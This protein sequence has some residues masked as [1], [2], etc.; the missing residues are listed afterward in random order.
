MIDKHKGTPF[1][2]QRILR[3]FA[4]D[5]ITRVVFS[6]DTNSTRDPTNE[7]CQRAD[8]LLTNFGQ[9]LATVAPWA[10]YLFNIGL[11]DK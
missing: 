6:V 1:E 11:T 7:V 5:C 9:V 10:C 4:M 8:T 2:M 3:G